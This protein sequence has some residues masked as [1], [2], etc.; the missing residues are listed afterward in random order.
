[1]P[2]VEKEVKI[3]NRLGLH[4]RAAGCFRRAAAGFESE[5]KVRRLSMTANAK[6]LL[7]L[8][9]LEA[10]Q[11]TSIR[12]MARGQDAEQ[13]IQTLVKLVENRFGEKE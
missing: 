7:G 12:I 1:M 11:G 4:A 3:I 6:S 5:I 2:W 8:M 13:A 10:G 9:A